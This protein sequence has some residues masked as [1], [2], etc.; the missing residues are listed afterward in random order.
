[1]KAEIFSSDFVIGLSIFLTAICVFGIFY[2][3]LQNDITDYKIRNEIQSKAIGIADLLVTSS[4][5]PKY[6]N[7]NNVNVIGLYDDG[8][9]NLTKFEELKNIDYYTVKRFL[10]VG[11]YDLYIELKN[12]SGYVLTNGTT[13]YEFGREESINASQTFYVE[14]YGIS[15]LNGNITKTIIGVV[16][17]I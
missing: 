5:D 8:L 4:G 12:S 17:W 3:S 16:V 11:G 15:R 14:R 6:W 9:I 13:V 10:G 2:I 1:M 7:S